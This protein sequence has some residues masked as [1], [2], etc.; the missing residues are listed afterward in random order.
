MP[1]AM[2]SWR[3]AVLD[4][5]KEAARLHEQ[6][7]L[8]TQI[9]ATPGSIDV[10]SAIVQ[11]NIPLLFRPLDGLL[12]T[13]L[14]KP[15]PGII[16]TTERSLAV[17]R[18]TG[19][20]ELGHCYM[21]HEISLDKKSILKRFPFG[22]RSYDPREAAAD[23]F[24]ASF[25]L[26]KWLLEIHAARH[27]WNARALHDPL[28]VYQLSLRLGTSFDATCRSLKQHGIIG[29]DVMDRLI[30]IKPKKIKQEILQ[31]Y[32]M[33]DWH[34]DVWLLTEAD[35][36]TRIQGGPDDVFVLKL[37]ENSGAGYLWNLEDLEAAGFA[38][39]ADNR[40]IPNHDEE[41]GGV[42]ERVLTARL[43]EPERG[44]SGLISLNETRPWAE[45]EPPADQLT[46]IYD[47]YGKELGQPRAERHRLA[48][49]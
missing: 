43:N 49:A 26:P 23:A 19:A 15:S 9:E 29:A 22:S 1:S 46:L 28:I 39:V 14:P 2:P 35:S 18:F 17:Q 6:L 34:P 48:A 25:L 11:L 42:V 20:H 33:D 36:A 45:D 40:H 41:V 30:G 10:F 31:R 3:E 44:R 13:F 27:R 38:I 8:R 47:L 21:G 37:Q 7:G 4:G 16:V 24:A 5:V 12:G 32:E